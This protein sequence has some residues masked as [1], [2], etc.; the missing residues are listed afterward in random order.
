MQ[1]DKRKYSVTLSEK[2]RRVCDDYV[3]NLLPGI[4]DK[5][6]EEIP[7]EH[8]DVLHETLERMEMNAQKYL[9]DMDR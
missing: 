4:C 1:K 2:G 9:Y 3:T 6:F 8:L 7:E 5:L